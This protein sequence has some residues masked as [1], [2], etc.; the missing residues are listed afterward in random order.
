MACIEAGKR[1]RRIRNL[2]NERFLY[3][4]MALLLAVLP[5]FI[6]YITILTAP[7]ALYLAIRH[8]SSPS[9]IIPRTKIR[10]VLAIVFS[11]L[12]IAGW[13]YGLYRLIV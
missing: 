9:S 7:A 4:N 3:D 2:E 12:Q 10:Y 1:K 6:F 8:W 5:L 11:V 13:S